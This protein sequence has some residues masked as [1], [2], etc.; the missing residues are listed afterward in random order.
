MRALGHPVHPMVV[1]FPLALLGLTPLADA[2]A[3]LG[4]APELRSFA[5]VSELVGLVLGLLAVITGFAD[6]MK[7][8]DPSPELTKHALLHGGLA[9]GM[10]S[11]FAIGFSLRG[12]MGAPLRTPVLVFECLGLVCL[13][14]AGWLGGHLVFRHGVGVTPGSEQEHHV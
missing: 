9:V 4:F 8:R 2:G 12:P 13:A 14:A 7:I 5:Y 1:A 3:A 11:L 10:L 6:F